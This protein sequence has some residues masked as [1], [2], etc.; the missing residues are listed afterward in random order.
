MS[1]T[2]NPFVGFIFL[3]HAMGGLF[4]YSGEKELATRLSEGVV[5]ELPANLMSERR[6]VLSVNKI[7]RLLENTY[8]IAVEYQKQHKVGFIG[9]AVLAN[10]FKWQLKSKNYPDDFVEMATEG[11][12][13]TMATARAGKPNKTS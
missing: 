8:A 5:K 3:G 10:G 2:Q 11:L 6:K 7:T 9:R 1:D 12:V 13:V 4:D